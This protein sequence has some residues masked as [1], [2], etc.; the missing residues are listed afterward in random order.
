MKPPTLV[1][2]GLALCALVLLYGEIAAG[3]VATWWTN[4]DYSHGFLIVPLCAYLVW[5]RRDRLAAMTPRPSTA[6]A[7]VVGASLLV[8]IVGQLG[9]ELFLSRLSLIGVVGGS[10][11]F[12]LGWRYLA[13]LAFPLG[14]T[15]LMIPLPAIVFNQI[16]LPLQTTASRVAE[17]TLSTV[18]VPVLRDGNLIHLSNT[19]LEVAEACSGIR[20]LISLLTLSIVFGYFTETAS[21]RRL[22]LA[23]ATVPIA[24][25]ANAARVAGTGVLAHAAGP[26]AAEGFFHT[27][28]GWLVFMVATAMLF[29]LQWM[30]GRTSNRMSAQSTAE[31]AL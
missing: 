9:A 3:L 18:G 27:F 24:I 13:T 11:L 10:V 1:A 16:T 15:L 4:D 20:S 26:A 5:E 30:L 8:L 2:L 14:C 29:A 22:V 23:L 25:A 7:A 31:L 12:F 19:T 6:G 21:T 17:W 28:A